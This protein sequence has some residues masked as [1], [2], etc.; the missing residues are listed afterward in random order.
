MRE[1][2]MRICWKLVKLVKL[3]I[4]EQKRMKSVKNQQNQQ[5][6]NKVTS[7][8]TLLSIRKYVAHLTCLSSWPR[9]G[10]MG[11]TP[12]TCPDMPET[13]RHQRCPT[14]HK[15]LFRLKSCPFLK[16]F[17]VKHFLFCLIFDKEWLVMGKFCVK[18]I[19]NIGMTSGINTKITRMSIILSRVPLR[20]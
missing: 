14:S 9:P 20:R 6:N 10:K 5:K 12:S 11:V 16:L 1:N 7:H 8:I 13:T 18:I 3:S 2:L 17:L 19:V 4:K 15:L